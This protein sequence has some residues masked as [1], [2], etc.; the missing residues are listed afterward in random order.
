MRAV[1][2]AN[3]SCTVVCRCLAMGHTRTALEDGTTSGRGGGF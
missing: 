3:T 2:I 1:L